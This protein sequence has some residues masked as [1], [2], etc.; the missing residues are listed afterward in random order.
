MSGRSSSGLLLLLLAVGASAQ[1]PFGPTDPFESRFKTKPT[2][3]IRFRVPE[4]GG[5]VRLT[6]KNPVHYEKE[7]FWEG[8]GEVTIEYQD[9]RITADR[10]RY[11]FPTKTATLEGNVVVDQGPTRLS[12]SRGV[13][14]VEDKTGRLENA[15][16]DL[17]PT[18]HV[19][20]DAIEKIGPATYRIEKGVFTSCDLPRPEW[21]FYLSRADVT[22]DDY[23]RMKN[24]SFR[25]G[26]VPVL[27]TPWLV[28]PTKQDRASGFLVPGVGYNSRRGGYL[29]LSYY[30]VTGR[31]TDSTTQLDLYSRG[32]VGVGEELR[33]TPTPEA[34]GIL[35]GYAIRDPEA[36]V[37]VPIEEAP[38][39]GD[40]CVMTDGRS[41]V[42]ARREKTRW[43]ARL[44]HVSNDLPFDFRGVLSVREYSDEQF[45]RDYE[46]AFALSSSRQTLSRGFLT[47][48]FGDD[49]VNL[50]VERSETFFGTK[51]VSERVPS[52]EYSRRTSRIGRSPFFLALESSLS[53]L[54]VNRG[55]GLPHG[56]Y[57]RADF[58]PTLSI[59]WKTVPWLSVTAKGGGRWTGYSD[60]TDEGRT[61][62]VGDSISRSYGEAGVSIV[63]PS[64]SRIYEGA[65]GTFGRFKHVIEP[66][67]D[68]EY[69]SDVD[70]PLRIPVFDEVD[71]AL[72]RNQVRYAIVNRLLARPA[73]TKA[74]GATEIASLEIAQTH[75][76]RLPQL[77]SGTST[78]FES[79]VARTGPVEATLRVV[80]G[81]L[82]SFDA[83]A[84]YDAHVDRITAVSV[85][86]SVN[87]RTNYVNA[88]WFGSRPVSATG[89]ALTPTDQI[90]IAAGV[91]LTKAFRVDTQLN[92]DAQQNR[93]LEDRSLV[94]FN[95]SCYA[96]FL[97]VRQLRLP[98]TTRRDYRLVLN[99]K[100]V[101]TL[102]DV[103]GSLDR[104]FGG[105]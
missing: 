81:S 3:Q 10:A 44:D 34:A 46:R 64:V 5:E 13:F 102:L 65:I 96:L 55:P 89:L 103:N 53:Y 32:A 63:G 67:V 68:Y 31:S 97:E 66:R 43:K 94:T 41:G 4:K 62:F 75:A 15:T 48:N 98:P 51:V 61:L 29:G 82:F 60:S 26:P 79:F 30:W 8:S 100:D 18:Y 39:G 45:L 85:A 72:G 84:A 99:L 14:R 91:D 92:Y 76:F 90:R 52:L 71:T 40:A 7:V 58:H 95:G 2:F 101:G 25:A 87:W 47:K 12:G 16:A 19:V 20:A 70:D 77:P 23:A 6:T 35:Q 93:L 50:R 36:T 86:T 49:S 73:E 28:W 42:F 78:S 69:V 56:E 59:P 11:D 1:T 105:Q 37:C 88:T 21:S 17:A 74:G 83:R 9:V 104:L 80:P 38:E 33:W 54:F 27:Y 57:G 24:V 22:L